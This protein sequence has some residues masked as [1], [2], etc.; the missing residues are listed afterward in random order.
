[1]GMKMAPYIGFPLAIN[2]TILLC[3]GVFPGSN[4]W[5]NVTFATSF[6]NTDYLMV[7]SV[8]SRGSVHGSTST[9]SMNLD[10]SK[11]PKNV[12]SCYMGVY[13]GN[14]NYPGHYLLIGFN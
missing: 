5:M 12:S 9:L 13:N 3:W 8:H 4:T 11:Q 1:M 14:T 6:S 7:S 2:N 10:N